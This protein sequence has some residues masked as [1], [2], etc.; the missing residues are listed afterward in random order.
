M[1]SLFNEEAYKE[2]INRINNLKDNSQ[3]QWGKMSLGQMAWHCQYPL[4]IAIKNKES[5][6]KANFIIRLFVKK[7]M[8]NDKPWRKSLPTAPALKTK[9]EKDIT[10]EIEKLKELVIEF[11]ALKAR[12]KWHSHPVFGVLTHDQWGKME[13]KHL[14]HHLKQFGV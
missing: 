8:Y 13:Y 2:V 4:K 7:S 6:K 10:T 9:E 11:Y 12:E 5:D 1:K 14:D 3:R